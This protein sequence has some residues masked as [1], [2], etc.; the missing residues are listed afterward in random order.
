MKGLRSLFMVLLLANFSLAFS[1][2]QVRPPFLQDDLPHPRIHLGMLFGAASERVRIQGAETQLETFRL[3]ETRFFQANNGILLGIEIEYRVRHHWGFRTQPAM[4]LTDGTFFL[5][6]PNGTAGRIK[7]ERSSFS[8]PLH[9]K[10]ALQEHDYG[11]YGMGGLRWQYETGRIFPARPFALERS[12]VTA[13][14]GVGYSIKMNRGS[15]SFEM[16]WAHGL[17]DQFPT[18]TSFRTGLPDQVYLDRL[19]IALVLR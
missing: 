1:Q 3:G 7:V 15:L 10:Y 17:I 11:L 19:L 2:A 9:F 6:D 16:V 13:D 18:S 8:V 14:L 4:S 12:N 5:T